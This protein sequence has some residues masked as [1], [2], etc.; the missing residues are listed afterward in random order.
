MTRLQEVYGSDHNDA[1][2]ADGVTFTVDH[3]IY[4]YG[5]SIYGPKKE[6]EG[7][8]QVDTV[9]TRKKK[10]IV[11]ETINISGAGVILPV[12]FERPVKIDKGYPYTLELYIKG[13]LSHLGASG[14]TQI[15]HGKVLFTFKDA[16]KVKNNRSSTK[17]GQIP[18]LYYMIRNKK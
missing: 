17:K 16:A 13:P 1:Y 5:F 7:K 18:R 8:Y 9:L 2:V 15:Q 3:N 14:Q 11:L 6:G 4:L 10:D 12:M